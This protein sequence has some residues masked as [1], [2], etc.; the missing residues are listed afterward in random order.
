MRVHWTDRAKARLKDIEVYIAQDKQNPVGAKNT[1][2]KILRRSWLL[3][4]PP[5]IGHSVRGFENTPLREV[6]TR[7]YRIIYVVNP[8]QVDVVSVLHYRLLIPKDLDKALL[9]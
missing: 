8:D 1:V 4:D 6:L 5:E 3:A 2:E 9:L 7:P